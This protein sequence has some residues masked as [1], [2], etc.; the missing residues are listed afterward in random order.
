MDLDFLFSF[1]SFQSAELY[2]DRC[3]YENMTCT[4]DVFSP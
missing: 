2:L 1:L 3:Y 4:E